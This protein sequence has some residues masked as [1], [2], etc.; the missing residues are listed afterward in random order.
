MPPPSPATR[1]RLAS[2]EAVLRALLHRA[3]P[4]E[5]DGSSA[6][7]SPGE[8]EAAGAAVTEFAVGDEVFGIEGFGANAEFICVPESA[9]AGAQARGHELRGG[10]S[11]LRRSVHRAVAAS[12]AAELARGA[13]HARLRRLRLDRNRGRAARQALRRRRHGGLQ[14][15]ERRARALARRGPGHR[16]RAGG[17]HEERRDLRRRS[18]T[19]SASTRS[20]AVEDR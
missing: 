9:R 1:L 10:R 5:A 19:L 6:W 8:V 3:P 14:H 17:L 18:S 2:A 13:E 4:A 12:E 20:G 7:S 16:L 11:R 15:E